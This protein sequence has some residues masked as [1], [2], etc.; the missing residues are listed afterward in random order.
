MKTRKMVIVMMAAM[1]IQDI[2]MI[3]LE[4]V[5]TAQKSYAAALKRNPKNHR[6]LSMGVEVRLSRAAAKYGVD[7]T[8]LTLPGRKRDQ[9][10]VAA[11]LAGLEKVMTPQKKAKKKPAAKKKAK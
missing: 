10:D 11:L 4:G 5:Q 3:D 6:P 8:V 1:K 9:K 7:A 2:D